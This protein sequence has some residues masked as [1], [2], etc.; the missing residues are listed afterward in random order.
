MV[1]VLQQRFSVMINTLSHVLPYD[2]L[3]ISLKGYALGNPSSSSSLVHKHLI[4][5]LS[6]APALISHPHSSCKEHSTMFLLAEL[7][8]LS[9]LA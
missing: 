7:C 6:F 8:R 3:W 5:L 2:I 1:K 4:L 9:L